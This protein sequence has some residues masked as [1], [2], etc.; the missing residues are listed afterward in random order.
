M[1]RPR[2]T[3]TNTSQAMYSGAALAVDYVAG[4]STSFALLNHRQFSAT[5]KES[6]NPLSRILRFRAWQ[7]LDGDLIV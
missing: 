6:Q 7:E 5:C 2:L 1:N 3:C 4:P